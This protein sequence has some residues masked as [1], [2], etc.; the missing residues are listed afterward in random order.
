M[1]CA[2]NVFSVMLINNSIFNLNVVQ[3]CG[4]VMMDLPTEDWAQKMFFFLNKEKFEKKWS[5]L[6]MDCSAKSEKW[7]S[8][9]LSEFFSPKNVRK[10]NNCEWV[11][12]LQWTEICIHIIFLKWLWFV[13]R[14]K[15]IS[16][17]TLYTVYCWNE[18]ISHLFAGLI[19]HFISRVH[20]NRL[21]LETKIMQFVPHILWSPQI[22]TIISYQVQNI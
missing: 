1:H 19:C 18:M 22:I 15:C 6:I 8:R 7:S 12:G 13:T 5:K 4:L 21:N 3:V 11:G 17:I 9:D 16:A 14:V 2:M 20:F 10:W